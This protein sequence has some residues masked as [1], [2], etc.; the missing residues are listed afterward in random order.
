[1]RSNGNIDYDILG[2]KALAEAR[3]P[4]GLTAQ[5]RLPSPLIIAARTSYRAKDGENIGIDLR[6]QTYNIH[7]FEDNKWDFFLTNVK[8]V[9]IMPLLWYIQTNPEEIKG[10][11]NLKE[12][13]NLDESGII[14]PEKLRKKHIWFSHEKYGLFDSLKDRETFDR[15]QTHKMFTYSALL[16]ELSF[17]N[18][19][20]EDAIRKEAPTMSGYIA[21]TNLINGGSEMFPADMTRLCMKN[22][23]PTYW[24][25]LNGRTLYRVIDPNHEKVKNIQKQLEGI[26]EKICPQC[27]N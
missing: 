11:L 3:Y 4:R 19:N 27:Y 10:L 18:I 5:I 25:E 22:G 26:V 1:M 14:L 6:A 7:I 8:F 2:Q 20:I 15:Y 13:F 12:K 23:I 21:F 17:H 9:D 24:T 16:K